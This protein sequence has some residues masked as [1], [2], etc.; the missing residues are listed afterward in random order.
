MDDSAVSLMVR[1]GVRLV[2]VLLALVSLWA[3]VW[4]FS[5]LQDAIERMGW[6]QATGLVIEKPDCIVETD[7]FNW[8]SHVCVQYEESMVRVATDP[9]YRVRV[10][11]E[12]DFYINST[13]WDVGGITTW[14]WYLP[15]AIIGVVGGVLLLL[16]SRKLHRYANLLTSTH[17][18]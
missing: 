15:R 12:I 9:S 17:P 14:E 2:V 6:V 5:N 8:N 11:D 1:L 10:G 4:G 13:S 18:T 7:P 16:F 3:M